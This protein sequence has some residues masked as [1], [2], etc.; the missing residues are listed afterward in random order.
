V[1]SMLTVGL[2]WRAAEGRRRGKSSER[3]IVEEVRKGPQPVV[4][5]VEWIAERT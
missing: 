1:Q 5:P 4:A 3:G 2:R